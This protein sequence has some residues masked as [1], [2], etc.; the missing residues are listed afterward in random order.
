MI[1]KSLPIICIALL[2]LLLATAHLQAQTQRRILLEEFSTAQ[3]GF[4]PDGDVIASQIVKSHPSVIWVT[5]HAGFGTDSMTAPGSSTIA[6]AFVNF[7]P[8]GVIDRVLYPLHVAPYANLGTIRSRWDSL[9]TAHLGDEQYCDIRI[10]STYYMEMMQLHCTVDVE[11]S[12][13]PASGDFRLHLFV[14][15]DSIVGSGPGYDQKNYFNGTSCHPFNGA[16]D[17]IIGYAHHKVVSA[18]P[19]G[20]WGAEGVIPSTPEIG[21]EYSWNWTGDLASILDK[22]NFGR[23]DVITLVAF[24]SYHHNDPFQRSVLHAGEAKITNIVIGTDDL[25]AAP[26]ELAIS[27]WPNPAADRVTITASLSPAESGTLIITD[28]AGREVQRTP[29]SGDNSRH[30]LPAAQLPAGM[31]FCRVATGRGIATGKFMVLH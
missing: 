14:V 11:F 2:G 10:T 27:V 12:T 18:I 30:T 25:P 26:R 15:E 31:Y 28:A 16:G 29:L 20:A 5:H 1:Q 17:P 4:C 6:G 7:A 8:S 19:T 3:C 24:V 9:I 21:K 13:L 22:Y 23:H